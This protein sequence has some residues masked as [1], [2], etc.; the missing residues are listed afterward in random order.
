MKKF[1]LMSALCASLVAGAPM[2][3]H[4]GSAT[5]SSS[6]GGGSNDAA[7]IILII[8]LGAL[9]FGA[10]RSG[11]RNTTAKKTSDSQF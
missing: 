5:V 10:N 4:A 3:G 9:I 2:Q 8:A 7:A 6:S 1:A 11:A